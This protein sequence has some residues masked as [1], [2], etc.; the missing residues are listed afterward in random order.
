MDILR[1]GP[2]VEV[3][4]PQTLRMDVRKALE[5][6]GTIYDIAPLYMMSSR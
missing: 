3:I 1:H 5:S 2:D 4:S 6:A